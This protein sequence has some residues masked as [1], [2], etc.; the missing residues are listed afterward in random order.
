MNSITLR[1]LP[2][3]I[4]QHELIV[5]VTTSVTSLAGWEEPVK[6][7]DAA[8]IPLAL[9]FEHVDKLI[10]SRI[11]YRLG[12]MMILQKSIGVKILNGDKIYRKGE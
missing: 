8:T 11:G 1:T 4:G 3:P 2:F 12:K 6:L 9:I 7:V 10:P 5:D